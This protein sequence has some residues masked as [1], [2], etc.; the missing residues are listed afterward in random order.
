MK[1][2]LD[3]LDNKNR[4]RAWP[5]LEAEDDLKLCCLKVRSLAKVGEHRKRTI[6]NCHIEHLYS[7]PRLRRITRMRYLLT[8]G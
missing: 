3:L 2:W 4:L 5:K 6:D 1:G 8:T 7:K